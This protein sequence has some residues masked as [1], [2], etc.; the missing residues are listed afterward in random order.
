MP[1]E[2]ERAPGE[3]PYCFECSTHAKCATC[4]APVMIGSHKYAELGGGPI[5]CAN[6]DS[7]GRSLLGD[8]PP[9]ERFA[10]SA[11]LLLSIGFGIGSLWSY[12]A[13]DGPG[14]LV[15]WSLVLGALAVLTYR[16]GRK[17][18]TATRN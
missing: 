12:V 1:P 8:L 18:I 11:F 17:Q 15:L 6:C 2:A 5:Q 16:R 10:V 4:G 7:S 14:S 13:G 3:P 9:G